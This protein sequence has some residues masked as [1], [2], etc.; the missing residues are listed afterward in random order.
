MSEPLN[1]L[2]SEYLEGAQVTSVAAVPSV[3][4]S[5]RGTTASQQDAVEKDAL[6]LLAPVVDVKPYGI[7]K[8]RRLVIRGKISRE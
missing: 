3:L 1:P 7:G 2:V 6:P 5:A 8:P 4:P